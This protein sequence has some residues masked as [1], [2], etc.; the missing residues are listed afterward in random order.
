MSA[1][2]QPKANNR[3]FDPSVDCWANKILPGEFY[4]LDNSDEMIVTTL[5]SCIAACIRDSVTGVG[6][7]N[8]FMLPTSDSGE[9]AGS[10]ASARY[11]NFAMEH[12]INEILKR[13]GDKRRLEAKIFGEEKCLKQLKLPMS[14]TQTLPLPDNTS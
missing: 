13:G 14:E 4:V 6:G 7:M 8:H 12:L 10:S 2:L 3:Y 5:G 11:G 9:W 1:D